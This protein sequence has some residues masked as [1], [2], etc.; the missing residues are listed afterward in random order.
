MMAEII[1]DAGK[2]ELRQQKWAVRI[3]DRVHHR[4]IYATNEDVGEV[5][6]KKLKIVLKRLQD[7]FPDFDI[8]MDVSDVTTHKLLLSSDKERGDRIEFYVLD[9]DGSDALLVERSPILRS[10]PRWFKVA[11]FYA[12]LSGQPVESRSLVMAECK[13]LLK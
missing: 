12:D 2:P 8:R 10:I 13:K 3:R 9:K 5:E 4:E 7:G 1:S 11:R 6:L